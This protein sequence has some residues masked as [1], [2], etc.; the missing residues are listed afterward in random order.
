MK[1][2][3]KPLVTKNLKSTGSPVMYMK[4]L[5]IVFLVA[6]SLP[7]AAQEN[8]GFIVD[9]IVA[10]VDNYIVLKSELDRAYQDYLGNGGSPS[11]QIRCQYLAML[12]RNKLMMAK[13]EID[14]VVVP[15][16]EVDSNTKRRMDAIMAQ[17]GNSPEDL[18]AK[19]G[20]TLEQVQVELRD[21]I[22]EQM[23][24][25]KMEGK[26]SENITITPSDVKRFFNK[27]DTLPYFS[28][29]VEVAQIV[30][31]AKV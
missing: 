30:R 4:K 20:K 1:F 17:A 14:S 25:G 7:L 16:A 31:V 22:R 3:M 10:K 26:I 2:I 5:F 28:A 9:E 27:L 12:I 29:S 21:Q 23:I 15:D 8:T 19:F 6:I 24:V 11:Q 13:A 18:E